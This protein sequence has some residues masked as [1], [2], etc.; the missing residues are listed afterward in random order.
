MGVLFRTSKGTAKTFSP[1]PCLSPPSCGHSAFRRSL[2]PHRLPLWGQGGSLR[3]RSNPTEKT[4]APGQSCLNARKLWCHLFR[5]LHYSHAKSCSQHPNTLISRDKTTPKQGTTRHTGEG[6]QAG[7]L[8]LSLSRAGAPRDRVARSP[9]PLGPA[10]PW[11][12]GAPLQGEGSHPVTER[13]HGTRRR[14]GGRG[15][16][17]LLKCL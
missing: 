10:E 2:C 14:E 7:P 11:G 9:Q 16:G 4:S 8:L 12:Y 1:S 5:S 3:T 13:T 15:S 17:I 6:P